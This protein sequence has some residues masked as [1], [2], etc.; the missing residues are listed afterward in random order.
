MCKDT[1][2]LDEFADNGR[3]KDGKQSQ[4]KPCQK[5]YRREHYLN[6]RQKYIDKAAV[7]RKKQMHMLRQYKSDKG[8]ALCDE[9]HPAALDLHHIGDDKLFNVSSMVGHVSNETLMAEVEKCE[10]ICANC[11]RKLH[12]KE[13]GALA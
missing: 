9:S 4:C 13:P 8:C 11:H 10:V 3:R 7:W 2:A 5:A 12:Y 6:N 1:K